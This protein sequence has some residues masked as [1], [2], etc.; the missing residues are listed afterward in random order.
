MKPSDSG[1]TY[2]S[3][4]SI[5]TNI[6]KAIALKKQPYFLV[7]APSLYK[8]GVQCAKKKKEGF[9]MRGKV[10]YW[11]KFKVIKAPPIW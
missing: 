9:V 3:L 8:K 11:G 5:F 6:T 7:V 1:L 4:V 10:L 2:E